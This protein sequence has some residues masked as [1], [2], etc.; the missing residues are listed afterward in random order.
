MLLATLTIF[1]FAFNKETFFL[2]PVALFALTAGQLTLRQR[3]AWAGVQLVCCTI[4]RHIITSPYGANPGGAVEVHLMQNL[5]VSLNPA[6][7]LIFYN[8][9]GRGIYTPSVQNP[10]VLVPALIFFRSAWRNSPANY[11]YF[12]HAAFW[13]LLLLFAV[14]GFQDEVRNFSLAS[15]RCSWSRRRGSGIS[16]RS[17]PG[18]A[19]RPPRNRNGSRRPAHNPS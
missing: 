3:M 6:S 12:L 17:L 19:R 18:R 7:F 9:I 11:R 2:V 14:F 10:I 8:L 1:A 4:A 16:T 13:P 5:R 15:R